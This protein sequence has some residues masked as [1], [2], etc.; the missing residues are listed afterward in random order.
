MV[1]FKRRVMSDKRGTMSAECD[2][3]GLTAYGPR[4]CAASDQTRSAFW[5]PPQDSFFSL[6]A[7]HPRRLSRFR[8]SGDELEA[9]VARVAG[10]ARA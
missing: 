3:S 1:E 9:A 2:G 10:G 4:G 6:A 5:F 8:L 7:R